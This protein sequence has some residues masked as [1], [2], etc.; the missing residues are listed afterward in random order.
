MPSAAAVPRGPSV[1]ALGD[2]ADLLTGPGCPACRHAAEA[3]DRYFGWFALEGHG[4]PVSL[5]RLCDSLGMCARH[6]RRLIGQPGSASRLTA[7]YQ[8]VLRTA[9][10]RLAGKPT[11]IAPCPACEHDRQV[12]AR[13]LDTILDGL[14]EPDVRHRYLT[15]GGMCVPHLKTAAGIDPAAWG[16]ASRA[17]ADQAGH[18]AGQLAAAF[19]TRAWAHRGQARGPGATAWLR[20]VAFIDG[21][22]LTGSFGMAGKGP[23]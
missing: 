9:V 5:T 3:A 14:A 22:V 2:P 20:A 16:G 7:V 4:D 8:Y 1:L 10:D 18:L 17:A 19:R 13:V 11:P 23:A 15:A 6:T 21:G 12:A